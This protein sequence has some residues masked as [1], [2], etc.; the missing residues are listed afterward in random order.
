M[1]ERTLPPWPDDPLSSFL[2]DAQRNERVSAHNMADVYD[3][4]QRVD[5]T[6]RRVSEITE[7][8]HDPNLVPVRFLMV[9]AHGAWRAAIRMGLS[10]ETVEAAPLT[11][12]VIENA[13]YAVHIAKDPNP[14]TRAEIWL[15]RDDSVTAERQCATEFSIANVRKTHASLDAVT[16][17]AAHKAYKG[18]ITFGGHPNERGVFSLAVKT[19]TGYGAVLLT[20]KP[21]IIAAALRS[22][23]EAGVTALKMFGFIYPERFKIMG[24]D[25]DIDALIGRLNAVDFK[26]YAAK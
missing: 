14:T 13:W 19:P 16:E 17:D 5:V 26:K 20:D 22:I 2:A 15:R 7:H 25:G 9:R 21:L 24:V 12:V 1:T 6:F 3:V 8:D 11:R 23:I 18:T 4:I 10:T